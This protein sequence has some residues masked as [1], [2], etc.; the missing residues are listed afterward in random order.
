MH[1]L[2]L[3]QICIKNQYDYL[4]VLSHTPY[5]VP[6]WSSPCICSLMHLPLKAHNI[7]QFCCSNWELSYGG[8]LEHPPS[9]CSALAQPAPMRCPDGDGGDY[10][11][12]LR[13]AG[14]A[15]ALSSIH[16]LNSSTNCCS[17]ATITLTT[18]T[19]RYS[20]QSKLTEITQIGLC[21]LCYLAGLNTPGSCLQ[22]VE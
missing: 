2:R 20:T 13:G 3:G 1:T 14:S 5:Q 9:H 18:L 15:P 17:L 16:A 8:E 19:N 4:H 6:E 11:R 10:L 12:A 7:F 21:V 22:T